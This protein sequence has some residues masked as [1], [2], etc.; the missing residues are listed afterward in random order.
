MTINDVR[1]QI[2]A[3]ASGNFNPVSVVT[4]LRAFGTAS[5]PVLVECSNHE[6]YVIKGSQNAKMLYNEY[7]CARLGNLLGASVGWAVFVEIDP[8]LRAND[9]VLQHFGAGLAL[10]SLRIP[11][12]SDR[13][14]IKYN[15]IPQNRSAFASLAILYTWVK[16]NDHQLI[17][18]ETPP[19]PVWS[20][21]HGHHFPSGPNWTITSLT[22]EINITRDAF[23]DSCML[24]PDELQPFWVKLAAITDDDIDKVTKAPPVEWGV[25]TADRNALRN[26]L[27]TRR[28]NLRAA[29]IP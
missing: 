17:Y 5:R 3:E 19:N 9:P 22:D 21:D 25:D 4:V 23:F 26:Y 27:I 16:A 15:D 13:A 1:N 28:N 2:V 12:A 18:Q 8:A 14:V 6:Q 24:L 29:F 7:V 10:G 11:S 20:V